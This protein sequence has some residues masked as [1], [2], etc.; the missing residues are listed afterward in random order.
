VFLLKKPL[1]ERF[2]RLSMEGLWVVIGQIA[3]VAGALVSVRLL[4]EYLAPAAF[5][6]LALG[7]TLASLVNQTVFGPL[8]NGISRFYAPA[9]EAAE[10]GS[11]LHA[12]RGLVA[13]GTVFV[14]LLLLIVCGVLLLLQRA[15]LLA[16]SIA[17]LLFATVGGYNAVM[18]GVQNAARQRAV[19]ALHQGAEPWIRVAAAIAFILLLGAF[20]AAALVGYCVA[21]VVVLASQWLFVRRIRQLPSGV[22]QVFHWRRQTLQYS[23]PFAAWGVFYWAQ[24]ASDRWAL[25]LLATTEEVGLYAV[26]FQLGYYPVAMASGMAMQFLT[27]IFYARVGNATDG[28]RNAGV[29]RLSGRLMRWSLA[30]TGVFGAIAFMLHAEIFGVFLAREYW[31]ASA[32]LPW[33]VLGGGIFASGQIIA[34]NLMSLL[35]TQTMMVAKIG[36]AVLGVAFNFCGAYW[37]GISGVVFAGLAFSVVYLAWMA[38]LQRSFIGEPLLNG[39]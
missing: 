29:T 28:A 1:S 9:L 12:A 32:L 7:L 11:H 36:T 39:V 10:L 5:G 20:S 38:L 22:D 16:I 2:R 31:A 21:S 17:A 18:A 24:S 15:E 27:P 26:L 23:W 3:A 34:L 35:K 8:S 14:A 25:G 19:V 30:M 37:F 6:E 4:T 13:Q 33:M